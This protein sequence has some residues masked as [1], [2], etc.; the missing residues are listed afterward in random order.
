[1]TVGRPGRYKNVRCW[2]RMSMM[3]LLRNLGDPYKERK[4]F[5]FPVPVSISLQYELFCWML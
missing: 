2:I 4:V 3:P 5:P 1:M